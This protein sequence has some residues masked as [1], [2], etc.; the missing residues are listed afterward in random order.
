VI[1]PL[2]DVHYLIAT[3]GIISIIMTIFYE[4][5]KLSDI[6]ARLNTLNQPNYVLYLYF[7]LHFASLFLSF[8]VVDRLVC[9]C[10][11]S[12]LLHFESKVERKLIDFVRV[13]KLIRVDY[14]HELW[15][16]GE[17]FEVY[18]LWQ[19]GLFLWLDHMSIQ[20]KS[21]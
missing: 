2:E 16:H 8:D 12:L 10:D 13:D 18:E 6:S 19:T 21:D 11:Q 17:R 1:D 3:I 5:C 15:I 20:I 9:D 14:C 4:D 7:S